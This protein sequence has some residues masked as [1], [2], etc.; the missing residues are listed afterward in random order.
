MAVAAV[1]LAFKGIQVL[2]NEN[3]GKATDLGDFFKKTIL[4]NAVLSLVVTLG[5]YFLLVQFS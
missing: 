2:V 5:L 4:R 3:G 1:V